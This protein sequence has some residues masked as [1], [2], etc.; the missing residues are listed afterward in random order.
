MKSKPLT[1]QIGIYEAGKYYV[2]AAVWRP[3]L[4]DGSQPE[5]FEIGIRHKDNGNFWLLQSEK[6]NRQSVQYVANAIAHL[7]GMPE[8]SGEHY[9]PDWCQEYMT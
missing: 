3:M 1:E 5:N 8:I 9:L 2:T 6:Y 7:I 4:I